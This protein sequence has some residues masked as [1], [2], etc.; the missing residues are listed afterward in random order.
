[1]DPTKKVENRFKR[2]QKSTETFYRDRFLE[3]VGQEAVLKDAE[4]D[5]KSEFLAFGDRFMWS[6]KTSIS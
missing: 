5:A 4:K 3:Q 6:K 2:T 1:M